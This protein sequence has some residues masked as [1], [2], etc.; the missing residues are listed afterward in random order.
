MSFLSTFWRNFLIN[1]NIY[2]RYC[3]RNYRQLQQSKIEHSRY[4]SII[5]FII[6]LC[7]LTKFF[8]LCIENNNSTCLCNCHNFNKNVTKVFTSDQTY[9]SMNRTLYFESDQIVLTILFTK[10]ASLFKTVDKLEITFYIFTTLFYWAI[11]WVLFFPIYF[12]NPWIVRRYDL[13]ILVGIML[14]SCVPINVNCENLNSFWNI[15]SKP[16]M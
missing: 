1:S 9:L 4:Y 15:K 2:Y 14:N 11:I 5:L 6:V 10:S 7:V 3:K 13:Q 8:V 16:S 12:L